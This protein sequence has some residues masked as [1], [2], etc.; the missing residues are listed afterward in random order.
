MI[1]SPNQTFDTAPFE[2]AIFFLAY[3]SRISFWVFMNDLVFM[4]ST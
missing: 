4:I 2:K 1:Q 3:R